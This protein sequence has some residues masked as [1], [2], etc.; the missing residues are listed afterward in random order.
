MS[1]DGLSWWLEEVGMVVREDT[2]S[3]L[4]G[5]QTVLGGQSVSVQQRSVDCLANT[6][7]RVLRSKRFVRKLVTPRAEW[8]R[9]GEH[10]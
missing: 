4:P 6:G 1:P 5:N 10:F 7:D 3:P 9:H 2:K 8:R